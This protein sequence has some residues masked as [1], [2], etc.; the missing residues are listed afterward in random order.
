MSID[1]TIPPADSVDSEPAVKQPKPKA[2]RA[3]KGLDHKSIVDR[4]E[5]ETKGNGLEIKAIVTELASEAL[6]DV[7]SEQ[8]NNPGKSA[9]MSADEFEVIKGRSVNT[10]VDMIG[11]GLSTE[12]AQQFAVGREALALA[13]QWRTYQTGYCNTHF[14]AMVAE[15]ESKCLVRFSTR[16]ESIRVSE[17]V[18]AYKL[19]VC[20]RELIDD[21]GALADSLNMHESRILTGKALKFD[22]KDLSGEIHTSW[23]K[24][25]QDLAVDRA[26]DRAS[27][28]GGSFAERVVDYEKYLADLELAGYDE[29]R[30]AIIEE[31]RTKKEAQAKVNTAVNR[32]GNA[33]ESALDDGT[34]NPLAALAILESKAKAKG[35]ALPD[36][37]GFDPANATQEDCDR[38]ATALLSTGNI[39][40]MYALRKALDKRISHVE[41]LKAEHSVKV[42]MATVPLVPMATVA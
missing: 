32:I 36:V 23:F 3:R 11:K 38:L 19:T 10:I 9:A 5:S 31:D 20:V 41:K 34:V 17:W 33:I 29:T 28:V 24:F 7:A 30:R 13:T 37:F 15:I 21:N 27:T 22:V 39:N 25:F 40:A 6:E 16:P 26:E 14:K 35:L 42:D 18:R 1:N 12:S 4:L 2:P 8:A